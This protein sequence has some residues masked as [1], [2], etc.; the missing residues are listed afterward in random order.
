[1]NWHKLKNPY[2]TTDFSESQVEM[3]TP[4]CSSIEE[5]YD[6]LNNL[7]GIIALAL[8][9]EYLWPQSNPPAKGRGNTGG[10]LWA[11]GSEQ[12]VYRKPGRQY[13]KK[14]QLF[15][16]IHYNFSFSE[17]LLR[18]LQQKFAPEEPFLEF[19]NRIY[20][21]VAKNY[22]QYRWLLIYLT[23]ASPV[24][25]RTFSSDLTGL[26]R[27]ADSESCYCPRLSSVRNSKYGYK[28]TEDYLVSYD[29]IESYIADIQALID[30]EK[31]QDAREFY[32]RVPENGRKVE[33]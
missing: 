13:G 3:I 1:M 19:K 15:S 30:A 11:E 32:C 2:I 26:C 12:T 23:G 6:F 16:G 18:K 9:G 20:L 5:A 22:L 25:H 4:V 33:R 21:R 27:R 8:K 7:D 24:V 28:N 17:Q 14:K 29:S 10:R 31:I